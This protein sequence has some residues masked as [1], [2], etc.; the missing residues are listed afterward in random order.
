MQG[1]GRYLQQSCVWLL[2]SGNNVILVNQNQKRSLPKV[3]PLLCVSN[4][5]AFL[6]CSLYSTGWL[7][8][9]TG[10][11]LLGKQLN[12]VSA[13]HQ[14][15]PFS[16]RKASMQAKR[17]MFSIPL[18]LHSS[19]LQQ[20][21]KA[22]MWNQTVVNA[23]VSVMWIRQWWGQI[24]QILLWLLSKHNFDLIIPYVESFKMYTICAIYIFWADK[25]HRR[26]LVCEG[27]LTHYMFSSC[28]LHSL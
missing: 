27:H 10:I 7:K 19:P 6:A 13:S 24:T 2:Q 5:K 15:L 11:L 22:V 17:V 20:R 9:V 12:E 21:V 8:A 16:I 23:A 25:T 18:E 1:R 4:P 3:A 28:L 14:W 26:V